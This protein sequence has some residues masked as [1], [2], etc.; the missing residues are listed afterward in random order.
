MLYL[1]IIILNVL[2][3][4]LLFYR[5]DI[6][7]G[8][9]HA[10]HISI[11]N[12][13]KSQGNRILKDYIHGFNQKHVFYPQLYHL[14]LSFLPK[15]IY[16]KKYFLINIF[17]KIIEILLFNVFLYS[18]HNH[19]RFEEKFF[20]LSNIVFHVF[21]FNYSVWNAK[22]KGLSARSIGVV[23]SNVFI[24]LVI[25]YSIEFNY[26]F[27]IFIIITTII[28]ILTS[29]M[30]TQFVFLTSPILALTFGRIELVLT[31]LASLFIIYMISPAYTKNFII[32]NFYFRKNYALFTS[33]IFGLK[34]RYSVW[35]DLVLDI[36]LKLKNETNIYKAIY[37]ASK[38]PFIEV[39]Y[40]MPFLFFVFYFFPFNP[41]YSSNTICV[42]M[43]KIILNASIVFLLTSFRFSR[44]LGEPQ[45]YLE[46]V[47]PLITVLFVLVT[48]K[49]ITI[50]LIFFSLLTILTYLYYYKKTNIVQLSVSKSKELSLKILEKF[51]VDCIVASNDYQQLKFA[52][53]NNFRILKPDMTINYKNSAEY[54][55]NFMNDYQIISPYAIRNY[56]NEYCPEILILN[57]D[58]YDLEIL[59]KTI[60]N[61]KSFYKKTFKFK[62]FIVYKNIIKKD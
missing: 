32:G 26:I 18:L 35:R 3:L 44:F 25:F 47:F 29:M 20:I 23:L 37:Y 50:V 21:P 61:F 5:K 17:I 33:K 52:Q 30:S 55:I 46:F 49:E 1:F 42:S 40:G 24:Y 56:I 60:P 57:T 62:N 58:L 7:T 9:D 39:V 6:N 27:L 4:L 59:L 48:P 41:E 31:P 11:I 13:I 22:N 45:R 16:E 54:N 28:I 2:V 34:E 51:K 14:I 8:S 53:E 43:F 15:N 12:R 19:I 10:I 38:N 36:W